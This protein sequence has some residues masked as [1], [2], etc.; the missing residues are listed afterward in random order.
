MGSQR[1]SLSSQMAVFLV[2]ATSRSCSVDPLLGK[3]LGAAFEEKLEKLKRLG[4]EMHLFAP[5]EKL[6]GLRIEHPVPEANAHGRQYEVLE[7]LGGF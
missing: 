1:G 3:G 6:P 2:K 5:D 7:H 4:L